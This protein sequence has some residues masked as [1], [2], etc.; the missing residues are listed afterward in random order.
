[1]LCIAKNCFVQDS[2]SCRGPAACKLVAGG[3]IPN[4]AHACIAVIYFPSVWK[5]KKQRGGIFSFPAVSCLP[6]D[7]DY[8]AEALFFS[9]SA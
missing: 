1:M 5:I 7:A 2:Q 8:L 6:S 9:S 3:E 4:T